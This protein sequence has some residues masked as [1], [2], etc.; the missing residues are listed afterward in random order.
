MKQN[1]FNKLWLRV[2]MIVA[3]MTTALSG[4]A[5]A[6][7][8][9]ASFSR[10]GTTD[11]TTGGVLS[12]TFSGK[13]GYYQDNGN[14]YLQIL[15]TSAYWTTTPA[16]ISLAAKIGGGSGNTDLTDPVYVVLLDNSGNEIS[17][18]KTSITNHI[19]TNNGDDYNISIPVANNVYGVKISH[20]KQSGFNVRYFSFSLSY[21]TSGGTPT[22]TTYT[23]TYNA[24]GGTGTM[25]DPDSP[26]TSGATVTVLDNEFTRT[27]YDFTGW[28]TA[29]DG[30]G[31]DYDA[32]DTFTISAN[33]T[34]YAQWEEQSGD[35][36]WV[37]TSLSDLTS[38]D[39]FVIVGN[40]YAMTNNN[41]TS[42]APATSAVTIT[43]STIT[44]TVDANIKWNVSGNATDGYTFYPNGTTTT[45]LYCNTTASSSSNNNMRV[46]S[47]DRKVFKLDSNNYLITNDT[48]TTRYLSIYNDADW[49]GYTST[50]NGAV[51][52]SFYKKVT[53]GVIP[54]S[55][56]ASTN[57]IAYNETSGSITYSVTNS[58]E[59]GAVTATSSENWLTVGTPSDGT[60]ALTCAV[61]SETTA[62]TAT[63]T[64]TYTYNTNK[65]VTT[66]VTVTQAAAPAIYAT[67]PALFE[68]ATDTETSV[69]VTF[70]NWVVSGVSTNGK[71]IFVTDNNGNG[72]VIY[73]ST[74]HSSIFSVGDILSGTAVSCTLK[75]Y[76][77][78]AE[79]LN[80][81]AN[82]L[83]ITAGGTVSAA[84]IAMEDLAGVNTGALV[85]Y[86]NLTCSIESNKYYLS[87]G[88]TT[89]QV[90]NALY[91][92]EALEAGK[93]YNITGIYQQYSNTKEILPRSAADIEEYVAPTHTVT[94]FVNGVEQTGD[95]AEVSEGAAIIFPATPADVNGK[96]FMGWTTEEISGTTD[97]A[98]TIVTSAT[99]GNADVT[100]YA[101]FAT[102]TS[103]GASDTYSLVS[104]V[105][106]L[107]DGD[108]IILVSTGSY[109]ASQQTHYFT[110]ANGNVNSS[111]LMDPV[112]VTITDDQV[113]STDVAPI[114]LKEVTGGWKLQMGTQY[115]NI[116]TTKNQIV[117]DD[118]GAVNT[119]LIASGDATI[120]TADGSDTRLIS[121]N[122]NNGNGR[123]AYYKN[124]QK[125]VSI[126]RQEEGVS[127]SGY[128][129]TVAPATES[130]TVGNLSY[131]TFASD[132]ALDFTGTG[133]QAF[134]ATVSG[135][136]L[137]FTEI[138]KVPANTGVLLYAD[139]GATEAVPV[140]TGAADAVTGNVFVRG[141]GAAVSYA[142]N[143][144]NYILFNGADGIGF[145]RANNNTVA[146][147]RAYIHVNGNGVKGFVINL[148][149]DATGISLMED[150]RSQ[151][152]D[153]V[154][155]NLAG[156]RIN[157]MQKGINIVNG[158]K[159]LK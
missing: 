129:T 122:P 30:S 142:D 130:V 155:Y 107:S 135:T 37:L 73:Y 9:V 74:D 68:A 38:S 145:Y 110:V 31:T 41:G 116:V 63:V 106:D 22:P 94:F 6:E 105:N 111:S 55:I 139:G 108:N 154:I 141:E 121:Y 101:V 20:N 2:G 77:G 65:T 150:G 51:A 118:E 144:Q 58:V 123:F 17:T 79:L 113:T 157:K 151:M 14:G 46:G 47:G 88:T 91:A 4:T 93:T 54:P 60:I 78:F 70:D 153:G 137:T 112:D 53:G 124:V 159:I 52:L 97:T 109:T 48:Y 29:A 149:D 84:N 56:T 148:E 59:G 19:T 143:D 114:T 24:N 125:A 16:S 11:T 13:T 134:Y 62:R 33:T 120:S 40:G 87:D 8:T 126:Y 61:N 90:Y 42:S 86:E 66:T 117:L 140:L 89:L 92:F 128:C 75:K 64:L 102:S 158:K 21:T 25:T 156:Q 23:V 35:A 80:V 83:T 18:T 131:A 71:D 127:Y 67:I 133:I 32:D 81:D 147:N 1:L 39:V 5:W 100:Y 115:L 43:G 136:T 98:P 27:D 3:I 119:I 26:Y 146:T 104:D 36:Q 69:Y 34:L 28:N 103:G 50:S 82:D 57:E 132:N 99:M 85:S 138:T 72:F 15:N 76:N 152:E 96:T 95:E 45:W 44:G 49:R 7:T 10:S 12:A